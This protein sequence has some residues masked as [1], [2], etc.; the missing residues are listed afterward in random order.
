MIRIRRVEPETVRDMC[1]LLLRAEDN[2]STWKP[3]AEYWG[4]F[5]GPELVG[6]AGVIPSSS[7]SDVVFLCNA[8][9]LPRARGKH[10]Q[11][12]L[13][14]A[15]LHWAKREEY[16]YARTYTVTFNPASARSLIACGFKPYWPR[17]PWAGDSV[18]YWYRVL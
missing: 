6:Y 3:D 16:I 1:D 14:R 9:V 17:Y 13:I 4:A 18:C 10:L 5:D 7:F 8:G 12:R 11:R 15:R 2:E